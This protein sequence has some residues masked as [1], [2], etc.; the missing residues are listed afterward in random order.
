M[1]INTLCIYHLVACIGTSLYNTLHI[2]IYTCIYSPLP[3]LNRNT[4]RLNFTDS[5]AYLE[6]YTILSIPLRQK[7]RKIY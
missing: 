1:L 2:L 6:F 4:P 5:V 7:S 3:A